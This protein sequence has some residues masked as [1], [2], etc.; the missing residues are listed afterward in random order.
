MPIFLIKFSVFILES[1]SLLHTIMAK[2]L[3]K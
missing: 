2:I 1:E 3:N